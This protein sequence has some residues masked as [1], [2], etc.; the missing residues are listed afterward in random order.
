ML[1]E[2]IFGLALATVYGADAV[3]AAATSTQLSSSS[4]SSSTKTSTAAGATHTI[5]TGEVFELEQNN[6]DGTDTLVGWV[7]IYTKRGQCCRR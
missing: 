5:L 3:A 2:I 1:T 7:S 4:S 6:L